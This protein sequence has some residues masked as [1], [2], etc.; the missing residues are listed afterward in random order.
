M[1]TPAVD[2]ANPLADP[3]K[4]QVPVVPGPEDPECGAFFVNLFGAVHHIVS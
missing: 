4:E 1:T 2:P 3:S